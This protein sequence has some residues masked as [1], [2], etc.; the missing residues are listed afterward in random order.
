[1]KTVPAL[2]WLVL[3]DVGFTVDLSYFTIT[4]Y[5][6]ATVVGYSSWSSKALFLRSSIRPLYLC[7]SEL[8]KS[9]RALLLSSSMCI[10]SVVAVA[11]SFPVSPGGKIYD[12]L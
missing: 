11:R 2:H 7:S 6:V 10:E 12:S 8:H 5:M 9:R 4:S 1:M 3:R